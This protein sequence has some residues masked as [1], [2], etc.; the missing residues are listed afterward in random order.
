MRFLSV[1]VLVVALGAAVALSLALHA[2]AEDTAESSR[3]RDETLAALTDERA[4][5]AR[6]AD[7]ERSRVASTTNQLESSS[8]SFLNYRLNCERYDQTIVYGSTTWCDLSAAAYD[9]QTTAQ[10]ALASAQTTLSAAERAYEQADA[11]FSLEK[12]ASDAA[13]ADA[14]RLESVAHTTTWAMLG[15]FAVLTLAVL[16]VFFATRRR[17]QA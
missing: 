10:T 7:R 9:Q 1:L 13:S 11:A 17:V 16:G 15:V 6:D 2:Q 14:A 3:D 4:Q 12:I 5:L 8:A